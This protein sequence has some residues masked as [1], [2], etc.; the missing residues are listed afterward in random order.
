MIVTA[1]LAAHFSLAAGLVCPVS[2]SPV[3]AG[4][5][6]IDVNGIRYRFCCNSCPEQFQK[7]PGA[8]LKRAR[9][10]KWLVGQG[11][12]DPV[13]GKKLTPETAKGGTS[14]FDGVR[15][16]FLN[17]GN[18]AAFDADPKVHGR[19]PDKSCSICPVMGH[20][21]SNTYMA[22]SYVDFENVRYFACCEQ[23]VPRLRANPKKFADSS[24]SR[25]GAPKA[26]EVP[27]AW[28]KLTGPGL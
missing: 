18:K 8:A 25:V 12:F 1:I 9:E 14:D 21:L 28:Q 23:C 24:A 20:E 22:P 4:S 27:A 2:G 15:F 19:V 10:N 3:I 13:S 26:F 17:S 16:A 7:D 11:V 5:K 6:A